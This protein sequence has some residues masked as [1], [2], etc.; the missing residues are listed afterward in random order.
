ML[1]VVIC[2]KLPITSTKCTCILPVR[3]KYKSKG[4]TMFFS[5]MKATTLLVLSGKHLSLINSI[6]DHMF[7]AYVYTIRLQLQGDNWPLC[8]LMPEITCFLHTFFFWTSK[9]STKKQQNPVTTARP[10]PRSLLKRET[11]SCFRSL[12]IS[13]NNNIF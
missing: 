11:E 4:Q 7:W 6:K 12:S 2:F 10:C 13:N 1:V 8:K 5:P 9:F 3:Q